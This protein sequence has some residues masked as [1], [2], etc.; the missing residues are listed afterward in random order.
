MSY[1]IAS[2][3][4]II[5]NGLNIESLHFE[6]FVQIFELC[7][8]V[9]SKSIARMWDKQMLVLLIIPT[10]SCQIRF[11]FTQYRLAATMSYTEKDV[12]L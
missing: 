4:I 5:I 11:N 8:G 9:Y 3:K 12:K 6:F 10:Q 2:A 7:A 1:S